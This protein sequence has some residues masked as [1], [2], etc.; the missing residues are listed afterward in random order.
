M[1]NP[2]QISSLQALCA[3]FLSLPAPL[4]AAT[5]TYVGHQVGIEADA[6]TPTEGWRNPTPAK[7]LDIDGD[8]ILGTDGWWLAKQK[9]DPSYAWITETAPNGNS[10]GWGKWDNPS[11]PSGPDT[12]GAF[13]LHGP[14]D[15]LDAF[16]IVI[17]GDALKGKTLRLGILY[18]VI[19]GGTNTFTLTQTVGGREVVTSPPIDFDGTALDVAFFD[20]TGAKD[21]DTFIVNSKG[22]KGGPHVAGITFDTAL[23]AKV[24]KAV[25]PEG[26][27][28][29]FYHAPLELFG[30]F[31]DNGV[32]QRD[33]V[34]PVW[35]WDDPGTVVTVTFAGQKMKATADDKGRWTAELQPLKASTTPHELLVSNEKET[36][37]KQ[38]ILVG[39]VWLCAGQSNM[40]M[41]FSA[42]FLPRMPCDLRLSPRVLYHAPF[43]RQ[44]GCGPSRLGMG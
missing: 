41:H 34:L 39:D 17:H 24:K 35:G 15:S 25:E 32:L 12:F 6:D 33:V 4:H 26:V 2:P 5:I 10:G 28:R 38:N 13:I 29:T 37:R 22:V 44:P 11:D 23:T 7:P 31:A 14:G 18:S 19:G 20:I 36:I 30:L 1:K 43:E 9:S 21:G 3:C 8:H 40:E 42:P 16:Q 27:V